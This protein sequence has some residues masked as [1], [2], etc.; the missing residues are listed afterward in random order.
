MDEETGE[1]MPEAYY[2]NHDMVGKAPWDQ[3]LESAES[4]AGEREH[5]QS[6]R[7]AKQRVIEDS[8]LSVSLPVNKTFNA[9]DLVHV[10]L[11]SGRWQ[12]TGKTMEYQHKQ[13][14]QEE[15][16][17]K[18]FEEFRFCPTIRLWSK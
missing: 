4:I 13:N 12:K 8:H 9:G 17:F 3:L 5:I 16:H 10:K 6:L 18:S 15:G 11:W 7:Y 14:R 2:A 1:D